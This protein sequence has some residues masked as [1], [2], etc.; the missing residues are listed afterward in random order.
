M[1]HPTTLPPPV[2]RA[3]AERDGW[4]CQAPELD[5]K[6]DHCRGPFFGQ[7]P[8]RGTAGYQSILTFD[9]VKDAAGGPR[10]HDEQH[11]VLL[12]HWHNTGGW[13]SAHRAEERAYLAQ[14]YP[15]VWNHDDQEGAG[16]A[17]RGASERGSDRGDRR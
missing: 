8:Q 10:I 16:G 14:F 15:E 13:A 4:R 2:W 12:C 17:G 7:T 6:A 9:H 11:G 3:V 5:P 1:P